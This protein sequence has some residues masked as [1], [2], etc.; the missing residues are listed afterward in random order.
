MLSSALANSNDEEDH[1]L[2][3]D[4]YQIVCEYLNDF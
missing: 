1:A 3:D 2:L 4:E